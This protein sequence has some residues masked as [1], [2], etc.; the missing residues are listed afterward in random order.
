MSAG[1]SKRKVRRRKRSVPGL[2]RNLEHGAMTFT[3]PASD[4]ATVVRVAKIPEA[5]NKLALQSSKP[6][7]FEK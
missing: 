7:E 1:N 2:H 6:V 3:V 4:T 5:T